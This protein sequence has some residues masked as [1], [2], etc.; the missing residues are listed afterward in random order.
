MQR[1]RLPIGISS[2]E[3]ISVVAQFEH[4][5]ACVGKGRPGGRPVFGMFR[6]PPAIS[7]SGLTPSR[8]LH[9][10]EPDGSAVEVRTPPFLPD[11]LARCSLAGED[12]GSA[13]RAVAHAVRN[14][15]RRA[16]H[17]EAPGPAEFR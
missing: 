6:D 7:G 11:R 14:V 4:C 10:R 12:P 15:L 8:G 1:R 2:F 13:A 16:G 17:R 5:K 9:S 3:E